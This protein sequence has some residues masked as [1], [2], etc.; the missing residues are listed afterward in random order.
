[1]PTNSDAATTPRATEDG[2]AR[3]DAA[4]LAPPRTARIRPP[5]GAARKQPPGPADD[6]RRDP[7]RTGEGSAARR[8][9]GGDASAPAAPASRLLAGL[10]EAVLMLICWLCGGAPD[11]RAAVRRGSP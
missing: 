5:R 1:M 4:H 10:V 8:T 3:P 11:R 9:G 6:P 7:H 2:P